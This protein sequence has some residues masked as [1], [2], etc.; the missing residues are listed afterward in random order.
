MAQALGVLGRK[1]GAMSI[2]LPFWGESEGQP[3]N[4]VSPDFYAEAFSAAVDF[5]PM[6]GRAPWD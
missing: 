5:T 1:R 3:R 6:H 4:V 2:D